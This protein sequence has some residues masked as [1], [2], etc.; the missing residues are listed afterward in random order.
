MSESM[1][2]KYEVAAWLLEVESLVMNCRAQMLQSERDKF[3]EKLL[4]ARSKLSG[5]VALLL[6]NQTRVINEIFIAQEMEEP[7]SVDAVDPVASSHPNGPR[8]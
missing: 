6:A 8:A 3:V 2:K 5:L 7:A 1:T 4:E